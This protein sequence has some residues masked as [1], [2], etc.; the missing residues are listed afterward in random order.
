MLG[1]SALRRPDSS[2]PSAFLQRRDNDSRPASP[3]R[4]LQLAQAPPISPTAS[5]EEAAR[6]DEGRASQPNTSQGRWTSIQTAPF[7]SA[8]RTELSPQ[9]RCPLAGHRL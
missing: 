2:D 7:R 6:A 8:F 5:T 3:R 4:A 9:S 1:Y